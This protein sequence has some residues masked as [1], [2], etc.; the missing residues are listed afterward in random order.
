M[1]IAANTSIKLD[2]H[3]PK[4]DAVVGTADPG[5]GADEVAIWAAANIN[6]EL[7]QSIIGTFHNLHVWAQSNLN[8]L[9][10]GTPTII[11][12]PLGCADSEIQVGGSPTSDEC[13]LEIGDNIVGN[14]QSHFLDRTFKRLIER[15]LE[16]DK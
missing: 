11:H 1:T 7:C 9:T 6:P 14:G 13:R 15:W 10:P 3:S 2:A 12:G 5:T 16:E 4:K 8:Q